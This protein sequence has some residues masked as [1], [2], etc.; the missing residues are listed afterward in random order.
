MTAHAYGAG[1]GYYPPES[2]PGY[3][4]SQTPSTSRPSAAP[5]SS[6]PVTAMPTTATMDTGRSGS[7]ASYDYNQPMSGGYPSAQ[8]PPYQWPQQQS[9]S[10]MPPG[11]SSQ[12]QGYPMAS[13]PMPHGYP[14]HMQQYPMQPWPG[15]YPSGTQPHPSTMAPMASK[16]GKDKGKDDYKTGNKRLSE[17]AELSPTD[18]K[19]K[20]LKK[21]EEKPVPKPPPK[22][23]L[24]APPQAQ[25][26]WQ[27]F[28][29]DE[30][31]KAKAAARATSPGGT[32]QNAKLNV[33]KIAQEAG[34][35]YNKLNDEQKAYYGTKVAESK[36]EHEEAL[37]NW[38]KTLT[39]EDIRKENVYRAQMRK[40]GKSRKGNLKDPNAPKKP[41][42]AY[43]LFL[44]GIRENDDLRAEV[45]GKETETTKQSVLAAERWRG[46]SDDERRVSP[47]F[48]RMGS[49]DE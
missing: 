15:Y 30:L 32:V 36:A 24:K 28:F 42:S 3:Y 40:E 35:A 6:T 45:W 2:Y 44:K 47:P 12:W 9:R 8:Y 18:K 4:P 1:Y 38:H 48:C 11:Q 26:M 10:S 37:K 39:P 34:I 27:L 29:T 20:K 41:L 5:Q 43:F 46:L 31:N 33:A 49:A 14:S 7:S 25:S 13:Q 22:S 19:G 21:D 17:A 23:H 16:K